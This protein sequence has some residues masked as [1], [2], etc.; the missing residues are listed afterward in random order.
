MKWNVILKNYKTG[1][2]HAF[3]IFDDVEFRYNNGSWKIFQDD[4]VVREEEYDEISKIDNTERYYI[5]KSK[6]N[7]LY[8]IIDVKF[9]HKS[10]FSSFKEV[11]YYRY[12]EFLLRQHILSGDLSLYNLT[13]VLTQKLFHVHLMPF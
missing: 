12:D 11:K 5:L 8:S 1:N 6:H 13:Q 9:L 2:L 10:L 4:N 3:N 7:N